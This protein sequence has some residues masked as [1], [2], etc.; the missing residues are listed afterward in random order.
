MS[1]VW[2]ACHRSLR[3]ADV[4]ALGRQRRLVH[5]GA[6]RQVLR[7]GQMRD[8]GRRHRQIAGH[9]LVGRVEARAQEC[10][11]SSPVPTD[12]VAGAASDRRGP[13]QE[14]PGGAG[15]SGGGAM[16]SDHSCG[17]SAGASGA[18]SQSGCR[19]GCF[20]AHGRREARAVADIG[21]RRR[22]QRV[23]GGRSAGAGGSGSRSRRQ[24]SRQTRQLD[25]AGLSERSIEHGCRGGR[26][27]SGASSATASGAGGGGSSG[28]GG[29]GSSGAG[30]RRRVR[31]RG[32]HRVDRRLW[33]RRDGIAGGGGGSSPFRPTAS[34]ALSTACLGSSTTLRGVAL[35]RPRPQTGHAPR[36][37][38][39]S[40]RSATAICSSLRGH[41]RG[42]RI[43]AAAVRRPGAGRELQSALVSVAGVDGPVA[44]G[45]AAATL[46]H[47]PSVAAPACPARAR[48]PLPMTAPVKATLATDFADDVGLRCRPLSWVR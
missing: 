6:R 36:P 5:R 15:S 37:W 39:P 33:R 43:L 34:R 23:A 29:G 31:Q 10:R 17:P 21:R 27:Q 11:P 1:W 22:R 45:L 13:E 24:V 2:I 30:G 12:R 26:R 44:A 32:G 48:P 38:L 40:T 35:D 41:V 8:L 28:A 25:G 19:W 14:G 47:S 9:R 16:C 20:E 7:A 42:G 3:Y 4:G 18:T 46:S